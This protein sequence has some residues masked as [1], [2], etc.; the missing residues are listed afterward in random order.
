MPLVGCREEAPYSARGRQLTVHLDEY[1]L[2][3]QNT[4]SEPGQLQLTVVNDGARAHNLRIKLGRRDLGG[5]GTLAPG[6]RSTV[7]VSVPRGSYRVGSTLS[8]DE[9]LGLYGS[10]RAR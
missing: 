9:T 2:R 8:N 1:L 4:H 3:P 10:L 6:R 7:S 5:T